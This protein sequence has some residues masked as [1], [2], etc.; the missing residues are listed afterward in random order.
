VAVSK[1]SVRSSGSPGLAGSSH[2]EDGDDRIKIVA[3]SGM[4]VPLAEKIDLGSLLDLRLLRGQ[5]VPDFATYNIARSHHM[6]CSISAE[7]A[8]EKCEMEW[9]FA[10]QVIPPSMDEDVT[11][12]EGS[13]AFIQA[14]ST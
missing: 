4:D 2:T 8:G 9:K 1:T 13:E 14:T 5:L 10:I 11:A 3:R 12:D 7:C 6:E